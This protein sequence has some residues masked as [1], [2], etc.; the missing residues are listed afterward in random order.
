MEVSLSE[1]MFSFS[2]IL[3]TLS[4]YIIT[5]FWFSLFISFSL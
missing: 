4:A 2:V 3:L 5:V 1:L